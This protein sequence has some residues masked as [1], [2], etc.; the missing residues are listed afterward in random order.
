MGVL[1]TVL[2]ARG[3][4]PAQQ[5]GT[6]R[7]VVACLGV[8]FILVGAALIVGNGLAR[9]AEPDGDLPAGTPVSI[10]LIQ[11]GLGA[12]GVGCLVAIFA[13]I[14]FGPG[15]RKF[16]ITLPFL[17]TRPGQGETVGRT[18]FGIVAALAVV[19]MVAVSVRTIRRIRGR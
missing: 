12:G 6:P 2:T 19:L 14:A 5:D 11:Y 1:I 8:M 13:W 3:A 15:P 4:I 17:G 18:L 7:W 9:G 16:A 10:R